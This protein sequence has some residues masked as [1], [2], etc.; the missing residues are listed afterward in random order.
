MFFASLFSLILGQFSKEL[1]S[2]L[3][4]LGE[5]EDALLTG[6]K[7]PTENNIPLLF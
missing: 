3:T 4:L 7:G 6:L 1:A 5:V 2:S